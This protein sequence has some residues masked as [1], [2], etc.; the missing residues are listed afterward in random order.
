MV[1]ENECV[2]TCRMFMT[3]CLGVCEGKNRGT[4]DVTRVS[5]G[6]EKRGWRGWNEERKMGVGGMRVGEGKGRVRKGEKEGEE[7]GDGLEQG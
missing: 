6:K 1:G 3:R 7:G 5:E 2:G 4:M